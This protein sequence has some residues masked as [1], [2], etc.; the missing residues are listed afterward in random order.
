MCIRG[1]VD[2]VRHVL[3]REH[4]FQVRHDVF[5]AAG[6]EDGVDVLDDKLEVGAA[7]GR[8][9]FIFGDKVFPLRSER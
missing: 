9:V 4:R 5:D 6:V 2:I 1:K 8:H 7:V 3:E